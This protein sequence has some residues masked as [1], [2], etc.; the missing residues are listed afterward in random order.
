V[1]HASSVCNHR[2]LSHTSARLCTLLCWHKEEI[3]PRN[4]IQYIKAVTCCGWAEDN[5]D[6]GLPIVA[7]L[8]HSPQC[9]QWTTSHSAQLRT[10][11]PCSAPERPLPASTASG[12]T[13][14]DDV[15]G[16]TT[17]RLRCNG[18]QDSVAIVRRALRTTLGHRLQAASALACHCAC[19]APARKLATAEVVR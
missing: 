9:A 16:G 4:A 17:L 1:A 7:Q 19:G 2:I 6:N 12:H 5:P 8:K 13:T 11:S 18:R 3:A 10:G 14:S 15:A